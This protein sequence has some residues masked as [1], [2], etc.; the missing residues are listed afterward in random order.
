LWSVRQPIAT[1]Y[2]F[3]YNTIMADDTIPTEP[4]EKDPVA[5]LRSTLAAALASLKKLLGQ[6]DEELKEEL[7]EVESVNNS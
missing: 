1:G 3:N 6:E 7:D 4:G 5:A 2:N